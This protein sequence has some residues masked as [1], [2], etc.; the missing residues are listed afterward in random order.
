MTDGDGV[1][2]N[3]IC[4]VDGNP[5]RGSDPRTRYCRPAC[6]QWVYRLGGVEAAAE[7]KLRQADSWERM[8]RAANYRA[9]QI[10]ARLRLEADVLQSYVNHERGE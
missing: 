10:A 4:P 1:T 6:R 9:P 8:G 2:E 5:I 7:F 3:R